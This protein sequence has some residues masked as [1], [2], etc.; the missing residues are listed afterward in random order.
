MT[1]KQFRKILE[2]G[3]ITQRQAAEDLGISERN[4][5]RYL[6][7]DLPIPRVVELAINYLRRRA[8][9]DVEGEIGV[10]ATSPK[11]VEGT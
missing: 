10:T 3:L 7:G 9:G 4:V 11:G 1:A 2:G 5:R 6:A 8:M